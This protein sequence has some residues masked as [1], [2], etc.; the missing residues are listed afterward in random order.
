MEPETIE[1]KGAREHNLKS[2][3]LSLPRNALICFTG[4]SGSGKSSLAFD[5]LYAEGQRRY[6]ESL[7][8]YARQFMGQLQ[9]PDCDLITGLSPS[10]AIQQKTTGWNPRSTVGTVTA[11]HD[12]LR[13]LYA[14]I[15][16][17]HCTDCGRPISAQTVEQ[18][19]GSIY[20]YFGGADS[21]AGRRIMLLAPVARG[22]KGEFRDLFDDLVRAGF[23]RARVDGEVVSLTDQLS[24]E[25][26]QRHDIEVVIDRLALRAESRSRLSEAIATA[27]RVGKGTLIV[28][29]MDAP[30]PDSRG[31]GSSRRAPLDADRGPEAA[32]RGDERVYSS[33]YACIHCGISFE[34][35]TPQLFSFNSPAGMC[36]TC[37]GLGEMF[38]FDPELLVPDPSLNF[39]TPCIAPMKSPPGKWRRHIYEGVARAI[40]FDLKTPW[41]DLPRKARDALLYGTGDRHITFEWRWSGGSWKHG[42]TFG[43]VI[44]ELREKH[45][46]AKATFIRDYY[47]K[48]MR[49]GPCTACNGSRLNPQAVGVRLAVSSAA[50]EKAAKPAAGPNMVELCAMSVAEAYGALNRLSLTPVQ[51]LIAED[52]LKEVRTRLEFLLN[53]GL[54]YL[55]LDR[56][57]PSLSGG[58]LQRIRLAGQIGSG[59]TG[60]LYVLD[61]PSIGLH[62]R[63]NRKLLES[64]IRLRD[65]GNTV[66]VVEHD[67]ETM[68]AADHIVDFGPGPGVRGGEVVASGVYEAIVGNPRSLTGKFLSGE[69][70]IAVPASRRPVKSRGPVSKPRRRQGK[71]SR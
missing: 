31:A 48:F 32:G 67:E 12:F 22:Q 13:V 68:R 3:S 7:S 56:T 61:E 66:I 21:E 25:K 51:A 49:R 24:L 53:V 58:E 50:S 47:E 17:Q 34:P 29:A 59:L 27:I 65:M 8:S 46:K 42:D 64:L 16:V 37:D 71:S 43:G 41:K 20:A 23:I 40:G 70:S 55:A 57:A 63:D 26:N 62:P 60:V 35:P 33:K 2:V 39:L 36:M 38:D 5:T 9:K 14:R 18:I 45:R 15:G 30:P 69:E 28:A 19:I 10:I 4:V 52:V 1:I 11:I 44:A 6:I 54:H